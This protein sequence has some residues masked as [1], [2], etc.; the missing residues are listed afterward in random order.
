MA[1]E[2]D[3]TKLLLWALVLGL[4]GYF[5]YTKI[6]ADKAKA[7]G[8]HALPAGQAPAQLPAG[9]APV[10][11]GVPAPAPAGVPIIPGMTA[12]QVATMQQQ[13]S[14]AIAAAQAAAARGLGGA[15]S[16][17]GSPTTPIVTPPSG[18][19]VLP[20][21][22]MPALPLPNL[23]TAATQLTNL[24]NLFSQNAGTPSSPTQPAVAPT[25]PSAQ[26]QAANVLQQLGTLVPG[27]PVPGQ[28]GAVSP[29]ATTKVSPTHAVEEMFIG[30]SV[31]LKPGRH[32]CVQI[33]S[34]GSIFGMDPT[35]A[36]ETLGMTNVKHYTSASQLPSDWPTT[37]PRSGITQW[38]EGDWTGAEQTLDKSMLPQITDL[39]VTPAYQLMGV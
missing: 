6:Q 22:G 39:W 29:G 13:A 3:N 18:G 31:T 7:A 28:P 30:N 20:A 14:Q 2:Q 5:I 19:T 27:L 1:S 12:A 16:P 10:A 37:S 33:E 35:A 38:A 11:P 36:L 21:G 25:S 4:G 26:A 8:A 24:A 9:Q 23:Q 15:A 32:Y 17:T 34:A